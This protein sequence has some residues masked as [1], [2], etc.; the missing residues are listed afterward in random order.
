MRT[1]FGGV[2]VSSLSQIMVDHGF[3][4]RPDKAKDYQISI[5]CISAKHAVLR[6]KI[7]DWL[8]WNQDNMSTCRQLSAL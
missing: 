3:K 8:A 7:K 1:T 4:P 5:C 2:M 6:I